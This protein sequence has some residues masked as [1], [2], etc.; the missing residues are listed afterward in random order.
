MLWTG[1]GRGEEEGEREE[2]E[3]RKGREEE[4]ERGAEKEKLII[5]SESVK[6]TRIRSPKA[7]ALER[8]K[9]AM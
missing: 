5:D 1:W 7:N 4:G 3:R 8:S 9:Y 2:G 6:C